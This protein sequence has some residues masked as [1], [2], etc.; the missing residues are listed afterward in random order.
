MPA[1]I[2]VLPRLRVAARD[3]HRRH[4]HQ[5]K[6]I[7]DAAGEIKQRRQLQHIEGEIIAGFAIGEAMAGGIA[8]RQHHIQDRAGARWRRRNSP[9]AS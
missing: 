2:S 5:G 4:E 3:H 9:R 7:G 6:G 8:Q 1:R